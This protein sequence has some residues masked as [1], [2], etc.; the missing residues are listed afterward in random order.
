MN[1]NWIDI[2]Q[3]TPYHNNPRSIPMSAIEALAESIKSYGWQQPLVVTG[4]DNEVI[5]GH[6]RLMAAKF[7][8]LTEV[9]CVKV[10]NLTPK[11]IREYR[12]LDNKISEKT[13]W[14]PEALQIELK[15]LDVTTEI[16]NLSFSPVELE[17]L[18]YQD[19]SIDNLDPKEEDAPKK[20]RRMP[21]G[22]KDKAILLSQNQYLVVMSAINRVREHDGAELSESEALV[23]V[24]KEWMGMH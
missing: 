1:I 3:I 8:E 5:V 10:D 14:N 13:M 18:L 21:N 16:F 17:S 23:T 4:P 12:I 9:P 20:S 2:N 7:L 15:E 24:C 11:Q 19:W 22:K 6:T